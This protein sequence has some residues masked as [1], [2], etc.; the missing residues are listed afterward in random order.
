MG[1]PEDRDRAETLEEWGDRAAGLARQRPS[2][3]S[4][5]FGAQGVSP[6][7]SAGA[8]VA[9]SLPNSLGAVVAWLYLEGF[10]PAGQSLTWKPQCGR[11]AAYCRS[12][13]RPSISGTW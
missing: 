12:Q 2:F 7:E 3:G 8:E 5:C 11:D 6:M 10:V 13:A 9:R 1:R 4:R